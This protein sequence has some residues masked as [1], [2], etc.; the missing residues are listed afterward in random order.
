M[1]SFEELAVE[2]ETTTAGELSRKTTALLTSTRVYNR[3]FEITRH[4]KPCAR[5][6]PIDGWTVLRDEQLA[7]MEAD[8]REL[9]DSRV[10]LE[11]LREEVAQLRSEREG[12]AMT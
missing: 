5:L 10:E 1:D 4:K 3:A 2:L 7:A 11:A 8:L 12:A 6:V 9:E